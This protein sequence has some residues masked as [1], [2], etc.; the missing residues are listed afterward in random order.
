MGPE[1]EMT[2]SIRALIQNQEKTEDLEQIGEDK[3][4]MPYRTILIGLVMDEG[5]AD[6]WMR[7]MRA[8]LGKWTNARRS[9]ACPPPELFSPVRW[10]LF[11][12]PELSQGGCLHLLHLVAHLGK[13]CVLTLEIFIVGFT[14]VLPSLAN[15]SV[16]GCRTSRN[17]LTAWKTPLNNRMAA[18]RV[19]FRSDLNPTRDSSSLILSKVVL[20]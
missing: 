16:I 7:T 4:I 8:R 5:K 15:R 10:G 13:R 2:G 11:T 18:A 19:G 17:S 1:D 14:K 12:N 6:A 20:R 3:R 9:N